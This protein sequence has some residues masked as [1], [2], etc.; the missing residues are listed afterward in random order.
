MHSKTPGTRVKGGSWRVSPLTVTIAAVIAVVAILGFVLAKHS[1]NSQNDALLKDEAGQ[2]GEYVSTLASELGSTLEALAPEVT[3]TNANPLAFEA[4]AQPLTTGPITF[5]LAHRAGGRFVVAASSGP[6]FKTGEVVSPQLAAALGAAGSTLT[7]GPAHYDG[8]STTFDLALGP[9]LVPENTAIYEQISI[10][11]FLAITATQAAPFQVLH[12]AVYA[13]RAP[14]TERLVL[15]NTRILPLRPPTTEVPISIGNTRWWI[16]A[17][18]KSPLAGHFPNEAPLIVL[19]IGLLLALAI[20]STVE[21]IVRRQRY[22]TALVTERTAELL[23]SQEALVRSERLSAVGRMTTVIGHE[24]R[25]PLGAVMSSLYLLRRS[26]GDPAKAEPHLEVAERQT[27]RAVSLAQDLTS[28]MREREPRPVPID[29]RDVLK[30]VLETVSVPS[31]VEVV[32]DVGPLTFEA[33]PRQFAQILTNVVNNGFQAMPDGGSLHIS[34]AQDGERVTITV[35]DSGEGIDGDV[36]DRLF[37]PFFTTKSEGTGLGLAIVRRLTEAHCG[38]V[39]IVT[40]ANGGAV[41]T[42]SLPLTATM[43]PPAGPQ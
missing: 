5:V 42:I 14:T 7:S 9:P 10:D 30:E 43:A 13:S 25:N 26:L 35:A 3:A 27:A 41:A 29:L 2:A 16:F 24:L 15:A 22:A 36:G 12:A 8:T 18:A 32:N 31:N 21:V 11:P 23:A 40:G 20:S 6:A 28:Y 4:Q 34:A 33:D 1:V 17:S 38:H 19:V 37:E 39:S